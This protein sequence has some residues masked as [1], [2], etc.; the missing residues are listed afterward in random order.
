MANGEV[1]YELV[2]DN[3]GAVKS[4]KNIEKEAEDTAKKMQKSMS[5]S[6]IGMT[7]S[8]AGFTAA[9][10]AGLGMLGKATSTYV[11]V[12][13][14]VAAGYGEMTDE[15]I[16][17]AKTTGNMLAVPTTDM[18]KYGASMTITAKNYGMNQEAAVK[19][20]SA[21]TTLSG[22]ISS[23]L[24]LP[25]EDVAERITAAMR[26][27]AEAAE[28][29]G[30]SLNETAVSNYAVA[31]GAETAWKDMSDQEKMTWRL[32]TAIDQVANIMGVEV[33]QVN[34]VSTAIAA[35]TELTQ[36]ASTQTTNFQKTVAA[37]KDTFVKFLD[38]VAPVV[39]KIFGLI[40]EF[41]ALVGMIT[42]K[43]IPVMQN[44]LAGFKDFLYTV[45]TLLTTFPTFFKTLALIAG[46]FA[47]VTFAINMGNKAF[48][49]MKKAYKGITKIPKA[50]KAMSLSWLD[51]AKTLVG[52]V[53]TLV[54]HTKGMIASTVQWIKNTVAK[55]F[56]SKATDENTDEQN[57]NAKS[58]DKSSKS[59]MAN[60]IQSI[61]NSFGRIFGT[62]ATKGGKDAN[63]AHTKSL[64]KN[65][66]GLD[67]NKSKISKWIK[68]FV[69]GVKWISIGIGVMTM[70][71][72]ALDYLG[73]N[74]ENLSP[75][76]Q[77][78]T[79]F[80]YTMQNAVQG[81]MDWINGLV[82]S[83]GNL[84]DA[85]TPF[86]MLGGGV[87]SGGSW[88]SSTTSAAT[89]NA[90]GSNA[91]TS[92]ATIKLN[93]PVNVDGQQQGNFYKEIFHQW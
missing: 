64:D 81:L 69:P 85:L 92:N 37:L 76:M 17:W 80:L 53:K 88:N 43:V 57:D 86:G 84:A 47:L 8:I 60:T 70:L 83:L 48:G 72:G 7:K 40:L 18:I 4:M 54:V 87:G 46:G 29:L 11:G 24:G 31:N 42:A 89:M 63:D 82:E 22:I 1:T 49:V 27:E 28:A 51:N 32:Y 12:Q 56:N 9:G 21:V 13:N 65:G 2:V 26:G 91:Y 78:F 6:A 90:S 68:M 79:D 16:N 34:S 3:T 19:Y 38:A 20:G 74:Y 62:K 35:L 39:D 61:K 14:M 66:V 10:I 41:G 44:L 30:L 52:N 15:A 93:V 33:D 55:M 5:D 45:E 71:S 58:L 36:V 73:E 75:I 25:M 67:N 77:K 23:Y 59:F 50:I